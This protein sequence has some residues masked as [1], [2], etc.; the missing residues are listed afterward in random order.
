MNLNDDSDSDSDHENI[1]AVRPTTAEVATNVSNDN[2]MN[3]NRN[4][5]VNQYGSISSLGHDISVPSTATFAPLQSSFEASPLVQRSVV[6]LMPKQQQQQA[7]HRDHTSAVSSVSKNMSAP[8]PITNINTTATKIASGTAKLSYH[9]P[10]TATGSK[11]SSSNFD[12]SLMLSIEP[13]PLRDIQQQAVAEAA[14]AAAAHKLPHQSQHTQLQP[15]PPKMQPTITSSYH[16]TTAL[17]ISSSV[18]SSAHTL[19]TLSASAL[20]SANAPSAFASLSPATDHKSRKEQF[21]MFTRVLMK[22]LDKQDPK[23]HAYA[24]QVIRECAQKNRNGDPGYAS[25]SISMQKRLKQ[26]VG[27]TYWHKATEYLARY[28]KEQYI[29]SNR[30]T[31]EQARIKAQEHARLAAS[32]LTM[33]MYSTAPSG[34][35]AM[36]TMNVSSTTG[37]TGKSTALNKTKSNPLPSA[38][39]RKASG[40]S[41]GSS[42]TRIVP[43]PILTNMA[44]SSTTPSNA[45]ATPSSST[46]EKKKKTPSYRK[47]ATPSHASTSSAVVAS[48]NAPTPSSA[49][50]FTYV[51]ASNRE[52]NTLLEMVHHL[53]DYDVNTCALIF[54]RD[55]NKMNRHLTILSEE[56]RKLL[57]DDFDMKEQ[58]ET[59]KDEEGIENKMSSSDDK[60]LKKGIYS[61]QEKKMHIPS[62]MKGWDMRNIL[63]VRAAWAKLRL[64]EEIRHEDDKKELLLPG[65]VTIDIYDASKSNYNEYEWFNE[66]E[67]ENDETL[68]LIS[69]ATQ[70]YIRT[71]LQGAIHAATQRLNLDGIRLWHS[72]HKAADHGLNQESLPFSLRLGCDVQR[73]SAM[74]QGNAAKACQRMEEALLRVATTQDLDYNV[75]K[76]SSSMVELSKVPTISA[77]ASKAELY[78]KR[79]FDV[80]GGKSCGEPPFGIIPKKAKINSHDLNVCLSSHNCAVQPVTF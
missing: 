30:Y 67:A 54:N 77:A 25:L 22:Y 68:A 14:A 4:D 1:T 76:M 10:Q 36:N 32:D 17:P 61:G 60:L 48:A 56:Q 8:L 63:S 79:N 29:K 55:D 45:V 75:L 59:H 43:P 58:T 11:A 15:A 62:F 18:S 28:F 57:Y 35:G 3:A 26:L 16:G 44:K 72:Q 5:S 33:D 66:E 9:M 70:Y 27:D 51:N 50:A 38:S 40:S 39:V 37:A 73:Q 52:Y 21:L 6:P 71:L 69:E 47:T 49:T 65:S 80:Y 13:T 53:V 46:T 7:M 42:G 64:E 2:N 20:P 34:G 31:E 41:K 19:P 24:K 12:S 78:A 74:V 23:M